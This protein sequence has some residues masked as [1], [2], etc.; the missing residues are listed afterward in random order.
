MSTPETIGFPR[1]QKK[2][3]IILGHPHFWKPLCKHVIWVFCW[4]AGPSH[5]PSRGN[6]CPITCE[7]HLH[8]GRFTPRMC[9]VNRPQQKRQICAAAGIQ[10][11]SCAL[12]SHSTRSSRPT[13]LRD[14][15]SMFI[16]FPRRSIALSCA[17]YPVGYLLVN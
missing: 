6:P 5:A 16:Y 9:G 13:C 1:K 3:N 10:K 7:C 11:T 8:G 2:K 17:L 12:W 4:A 14:N 15:S